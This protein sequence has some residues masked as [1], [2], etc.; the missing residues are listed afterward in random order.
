VLVLVA[1]G[2]VT[3]RQVAVWR[4]ETSL[5]EHALRVLPDNYM[6]HYNLGR[7][8]VKA[9]R[10]AD[11]EPHLREVV[12]QRQDWAD[13]RANLGVALLALGE[14]DEA[15]IHLGA[16]SRASASDPT[17]RVYL[18]QAHLER[19]SLGAARRVLKELLLA[20]PGAAAVSLLLARVELAD[21]RPEAA[22]QAFLGVHRVAPGW[23]E[24]AEARSLA[25]GILEALAQQPEAPSGSLA[26]VAELQMALDGSEELRE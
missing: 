20:Q 8:L 4:N 17:I 24:D 10:F 1:Y 6:A 13:P 21:D 9:Q 18:A 7:T 3:T 19:G 2:L 22:L 12:R 26:G 23:P 14:A 15:V 25:A 16:A 11:A 5:Y